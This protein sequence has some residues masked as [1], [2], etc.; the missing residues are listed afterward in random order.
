MSSGCQNFP[1]KISLEPA[2]SSTSP[3]PVPSSRPPRSLRTIIP[4]RGRGLFTCHHLPRPE[5]VTRST[6]QA[7][8][9]SLRRHSWAHNNVILPE[10]TTL[11]TPHHSRACDTVNPCYPQAPSAFVL[12]EPVTPSSPWCPRACDVVEPASSLSPQCRCPPWAHKATLYIFLCHFG[13]TNPNFDM[14]HCHIVLICYI[15]FV[16]LHCHIALIC[17]IATLLWCTTLLLFCC[18]AFIVTLLWYA[19]LPLTCCIALI[20]YI[21]TFLEVDGGSTESSGSV[22]VWQWWERAEWW[23]FRLAWIS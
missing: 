22:C 7:L 8:S 12:P 16:L 17:Y 2:P 21:S 3:E 5:P 20:C 13:P 19:T 4:D 15:A 9:L 23:K 1:P 10:P 18:I 11:C 14:L 6:M